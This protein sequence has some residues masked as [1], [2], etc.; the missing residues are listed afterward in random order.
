MRINSKMPLYAKIIL[1]ALGSII[2]VP[3]FTSRTGTCCSTQTEEVPGIIHAHPGT[4]NETCL[5]EQHLHSVILGST[6]PLF[7]RLS[8]EWNQLL[9]T[10]SV[11]P[12]GNYRVD[13]FF[14][15][16][17]LYSME[18]SIGDIWACEGLCVRYTYS[19]SLPTKRCSIR[20]VSASA[21]DSVWSKN[22]CTEGNEC[23]FRLYVLQRLELCSQSTNVP[24][25]LNPYEID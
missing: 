4:R 14:V 9:P 13:L 25:E 2:T 16:E 22:R 5:K 17:M 15:L 8:L 18:W 20:A 10:C 7:C 12:W 11:Y 23:L 1:F 3:S 19:Y 6:R 24:S 21:L